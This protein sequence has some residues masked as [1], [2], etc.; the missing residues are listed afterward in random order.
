[1]PVVRRAPAGYRSFRRRWRLS[2]VVHH[3]EAPDGAIPKRFTCGRK[4]K[5]GNEWTRY[6]WIVECPQCVA[7]M[8]EQN[9][10]TVDRE[11]AK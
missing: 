5:G 9:S 10:A 1:M 11:A 2:A 8:R 6:P 3:S 4:C 7:K